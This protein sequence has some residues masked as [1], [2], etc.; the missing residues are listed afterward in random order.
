M[1][2]R[3]S[4]LLEGDGLPPRVHLRNIPDGPTAVHE[5]F[6]GSP[7]VRVDGRDIEPGASQRTDYG[8][9]CRLYATR[10]GIRTTPLDQWIL[11]ALSRPVSS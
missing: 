1:L 5:R 11:D 8:L 2:K 10:G 4:E 7:T 6:L 3:L 9:K